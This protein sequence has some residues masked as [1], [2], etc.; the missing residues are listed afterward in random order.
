MRFILFNSEVH[1]SYGIYKDL[2]NS[3]KVD[4]I[5]RREKKVQN[6]ILKK[7]KYIHLSGA[8]SKYINLPLKEIWYEDCDFKISSNEQYYILFDDLAIRT[9]SQSELNKFTDAGNVKCIL[10]LLNSMD[11]EIMKRS[12]IR[13]KVVNTKW[14]DIYT[15]DP[16]DVKKYHFKYLNFCYYS[17]HDVKVTTENENQIYYVG[18]L[19]N[20]RKKFIYDIYN[21][22]VQNDVTVDFHL[23][24]HG[25][26]NNLELP[27][28]DKIH[29][30]TGSKGRLSYDE[31]IAGDLRAGT[32]LEV[33]QKN[34]AGPTL[35]YFEAVVYNRKFLTNNR[36]IVNFPF[37]NEK[38]MKIFD[39]PE[40]INIDWVKSR[41]LPEYNYNNEFSPLHLLEKI[42]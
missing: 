38:Y 7:V 14:D 8:I 31:I 11:S 18:A 22:F 24:K 3:E 16:E 5:L 23:Q 32:I 15:F 26:D 1:Q 12:G 21:W 34:Q 25:T 30:F 39:R 19:Y 2:E 37:Y 40:N 29:Y 28:S 42:S 27:Y 4:V 41:E 10:L 35:R 13:N 6:S 9:F 20:D 33:V 17:K 36:E